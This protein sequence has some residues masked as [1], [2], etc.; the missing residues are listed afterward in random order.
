MLAKDPAERYSAAE[1]LAHPWLSSCAS[2]LA[3]K[4]QVREVLFRLSRF[5]VSQKFKLTVLYYIV[6]HFLPPKEVAS[7]QRV[8]LC[9][10]R[11]GNGRISA[12]ELEVASEGTFKRAGDLMGIF[13]H[14]GLSHSG[15]IEYSEFLIGT[16]D[17]GKVLS[18]EMS[19]KAF[20]AFDVDGDGQISLEDF[21][22]T[23]GMGAV[24]VFKANSN[25]HIKYQEFYQL[26]YNY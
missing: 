2:P 24:E 1:V 23:V 26:V 8:F 14:C 6:H 18:K 25:E 3:L 11:S 15:F 21:T 19:R 13:D 22:K 12:A 10:N 9:I 4:L 16:V 5:R 17:W 20:Q 7:L